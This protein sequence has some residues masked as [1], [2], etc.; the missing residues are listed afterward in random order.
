MI[1]KD[2]CACSRVVNEYITEVREVA[3]KILELL[4]E[5]LGLERREVLSRFI[6]DEGNDS[7]FRVNRYPACQE[8]VHLPS[9]SQNKV[10]FGEH[11]DPQI[12]TLLTSNNV[13]GLQIWLRDGC[14]LPVSADPGSFFVLV[15]DSLQVS[16]LSLSRA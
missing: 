13:P 11:S 12:L 3:C 1:S 2:S 14:W 10:G 7:V 5:G 15:G 6:R 16:N 8:A 4:A 9:A